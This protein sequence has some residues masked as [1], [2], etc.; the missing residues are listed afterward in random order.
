MNL[1]MR[2]LII[3]PT[4][5]PDNI[6][7]FLYLDFHIHFS[8]KPEKCKPFIS[9]GVTQK[10]P[11]STGVAFLGSP[12]ASNDK[13]NKRIIRFKKRNGKFAKVH[14]RFQ[15]NRRCTMIALGM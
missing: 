1:I 8:A 9:G 15:R 12:R 7:A 2:I 5:K 6:R 10:Q 4:K 11:I 14:R 13:S 3:C